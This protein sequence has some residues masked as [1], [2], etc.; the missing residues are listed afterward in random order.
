[1]V[2]PAS[3]PSGASSATTSSVTSDATGA[4]PTEEDRPSTSRRRFL[5]YL[6]AAP[7][8][9]VGGRFITDSVNPATAEAAIPSAPAPADLVDLGDLLIAAALPTSNL[10]S[11]QFTSDGVCHFA[12]PRMEVGQGI[13][14]TVAMIL[15]EELDMSLDKVDVTLADARPELVFNQLTG[16]SNSVRGLWGP[17]RSLAATAR[18]QMVGTAS[19]LSGVPASLLS[20]KDGVISAADGSYTGTYGGL[21]VLAS[22]SLLSIA[23]GNTAAP[24]DPSTYTV[25]GTPRT[26]QDA[27]EIVT[28]AKKYTL[29]LVVPGAKPVYVRRPPTIN[30]TVRSVNNEAAVRALEGIID[31]CVIPTGVAIMAETFGQALDGLNAVDVTWGTGTVDGESNATI[32]AKLRKTALPL[33]V[34]GLLAQYIDAEFDWAPVSHGAME[35]NS[36]IA[37]VRADS[38]EIWSGFKTPIVAAQTIAGELGL[39]VD[40]VVCHT[41]QSGGS[42]GR[43]LFFDA[44]LEAAQISK[45]LGRP[46]ILKWTRTDDV[47]HGRA[48]PASYHHMRAT[49]LLGNVT[50]FEHRVASVETDFRHGLG[51]ILSA[52]ATQLPAPLNA[53]NLSISETLFE[54]TIKSPYNYGVVT[55]QLTELPAQFHTA[56]FR[57]VYS[58]ATRGSEEIL[59]DEIAARLGQDPVDYRLATLKTARQKAVLQK[60]ATEGGW[61]NKMPRGTA[62][63]IAFHEE[64]GSCTACL[65]ELDTT[66]KSTIK[67]YNPDGSPNGTKQITVPRV[68]KATIVVDVG[69]ALNPRGLESQMLGGLTD[70]ISIV[71]RAGLHVVNGSVLE[72][73]Y[74]EFHY[75]RQ[76]DSPRDVKIVVMPP[77]GEPGGAG[78]LGVPAA[79][80]AIANAYARATGTKPRS[81]PINFE[82][83][84]PP[85]PPSLSPQPPFR[86]A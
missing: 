64:Y 80:G 48:A 81:F 22:G 37:D 72:G 54:T 45:K 42:F 19:Q 4:D 61:G 70:A 31:L 65:V 10:I 24:K 2:R 9:V 13:T 16:S 11:L 66:T 7:T 76:A 50:T 79:V 83:D 49:F 68:T 1:M 53:G 47:R 30:G 41:V 58:F 38:A 63:G 77:T 62:Q 51:E 39:P 44:A 40:K 33:A 73:S 29:D 23:S 12:L 34:P 18:A 15:A 57:S 60:A 85:R 74:S 67:V 17:V 3:T 55:Q 86:T 36:A 56:S 28:G 75:A 43:H 82:I 25:I 14:T 71:F 8:L 5:T 78:E 52:T 32:R 59:A 69:R 26:R 84:F 20:V 35:T 27:R 6:V 21:A 46:V